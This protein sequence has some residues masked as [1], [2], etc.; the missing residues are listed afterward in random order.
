MNV[1]I[2][3]DESSAVERLKKLLSVVAP[4]AKILAV[5]DSVSDAILWLSNY[6]EPDL[7]FLD[8]QLS[9]GL[10]FE[11]FESISFNSPIIFT[12]AYDEYALK[13]FKFNSIDYLLKPIR[14]KELAQSICKYKELTD[15]NKNEVKNSIEALLATIKTDMPQYKS[16][17]LVKLGEF[18]Q[19]I[20]TEAVAYIAI[21]DYLVQLTRQDG[22]KFII[23]HSLDKLEGL[24]D[25]QEFYRINRQMIVTPFCITAIHTYTNSR[26]QLT[27]HPPI[28]QDIIVSREKVGAFK[29][30]L[31]K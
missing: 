22:K 15:A 6:P 27:L 29:R 11:I 31:D 14:E 8:V 7:L 16:R 3:E 10:C 2:I 17:F 25:P 19:I 1:V 13:A 9:D 5:L 28:K 12:T 26:L 20:E 21:E 24:L 23:D 4:Q 30:W 18:Y